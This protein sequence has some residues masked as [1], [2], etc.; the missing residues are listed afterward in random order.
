MTTLKFHRA[1]KPVSSPHP[2]KPTAE[3]YFGTVGC[4]PHQLTSDPF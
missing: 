2:Q 4:S 1:W 3:V